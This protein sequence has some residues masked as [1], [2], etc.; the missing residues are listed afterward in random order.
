MGKQTILLTS[1]PKD[2]VYGRA[3]VFFESEVWPHE[4]PVMEPGGVA[5]VGK[6]VR[7]G[8]PLMEF[9]SRGGCALNVVLTLVTFGGW[10][11]VW[12]FWALFIADLTEKRLAC[13]EADQ[14]EEGRTRIKITTPTE[15]H[16]RLIAEWA[17]ADLGAVESREDAESARA[18]NQERADLAMSSSAGAVSAPVSDIPAQIREL[19]RLRAEGIITEAEF[20]TKKKDLLDRL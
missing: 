13:V 3:K 2:R 4:G 1:L 8:V 5:A 14:L 19:A 20:E 6:G 16:T 11:L 15:K 7:T 12:V 18:L 10:L 9:T 17:K